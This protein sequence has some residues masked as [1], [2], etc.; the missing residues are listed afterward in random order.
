MVYRTKISDCSSL[1]PWI[2]SSKENKSIV[3]V[4]ACNIRYKYQINVFHT[5]CLKDIHTI[6][7][8]ET[9]VILRYYLIKDFFA[10]RMK[11]V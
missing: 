10:L 6:I 3:F 11:R 9:F 4:K 7:K 8:F 2:S 1:G 5:C